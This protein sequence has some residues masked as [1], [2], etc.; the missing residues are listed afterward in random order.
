MIGKLCLELHVLLLFQFQLFLIYIYIYISNLFSELVLKPVV[1]LCF[2]MFH[3]TFLL[4]RVSNFVVG[5]CT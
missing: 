5:E 4:N 3:I 1:Q 2:K